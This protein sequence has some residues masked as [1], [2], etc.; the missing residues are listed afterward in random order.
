[1]RKVNR[2]KRMSERLKLFT[3]DP[4]EER[5]EEPDRVGQSSVT[6]W[7]RTPLGALV[8]QPYFDH[9]SAIFLS[10]IFF[11][12]SRMWA[13]A[14]V[15]EGSV[16][17]YISE[18]GLK[19]STKLERRLA[20]LLVRF[21]KQRDL[22]VKADDKWREA[23]FGNVDASSKQLEILEKTRLFNRHQYNALRFKFLFPGWGRKISPIRWDVPGPDVLNE[24]YGTTPNESKSIVDLPKEMPHLTKSRQVRGSVGMDYWLEFQSP[25]VRIK[26]KVIARVHEPEGVTNP[27]TL[28]FGHGVC[29]EFDHWHG[30]VDEVEALVQM[31][32]RVVRP[33]APSHGR[34]TPMGRFGGELFIARTPIGPLDHFNAAVQEWGVLINWCRESSSGPVA[35]GGSSMGAMTAH[36]VADRARNWPSRLQ[37]DAMI[38]I[39][40]CSGVDEALFHG[41][42]AKAWGIKEATIAAGWAPGEAE[43]YVALLAAPGPTAVP[44]ENILS[45]LGTLDKVTPYAGGEA[46][47]DRWN[48]PLENRF[49]WR[50]GHYS[51]P[52]TMMRNQSPLH[53]FRAIIQRI[54]ESKNTG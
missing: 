10:Q 17:K 7:L 42:L 31:G 51:V 23:F 38:L 47:L 9:F 49:R 33:E 37:P 24:I 6:N 1:M 48:V 12:I 53:K 16:E 46:L 45:V 27:P 52:I 20:D 22:S 15:A 54:E 32:I 4:L 18:I 26:D 19:S 30:L 44:P 8:A 28:I 34:R 50:R 21:E 41:G 29:V 14:Q 40:H 25:S 35:I 11:P 36:L 5:G 13:T 43:K 3:R 2:Y 39:T